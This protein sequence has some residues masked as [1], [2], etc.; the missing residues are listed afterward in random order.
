MEKEEER[1]EAPSMHRCVTYYVYVIQKSLCIGVLHT[2]FMCTK[3]RYVSIGVLHTMFM[4]TKNRY[5]SMQN[6]KKIRNRSVDCAITHTYTYIYIHIYIYVY[7]CMCVIWY[8][9]VQNKWE[10]L[11]RSSSSKLV[12]I[13][14]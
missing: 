8:F 14:R 13:S 12:Q 9:D 4:C 1:F 2:M 7:M 10:V 6:G 5:A 11:R 3:N